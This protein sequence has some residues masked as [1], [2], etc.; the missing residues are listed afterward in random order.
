MA[1]ETTIQL[2]E[3]QLQELERLAA[4]DAESVDALIQHAVERYLAARAD[5]WGARFDALVARVQSRL[6]DDLDPEQIELDI[7]AA[8]NEVR[9]DRARRRA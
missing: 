3:S 5:N 8:R 9:A 7:T 2:E 6:P 4:R 1:R